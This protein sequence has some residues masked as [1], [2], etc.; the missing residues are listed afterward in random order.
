MTQAE[1]ESRRRLST[2]G[3]RATRPRLTVLAGL[4]RYKHV[5]VENLT[6]YVRLELG[7]VSIQAVYDVLAALS[8]AGLV[9]RIEPAGFPARYEDR[10]GDNHHHLICRQCDAI[11]DVD[12]VAGY[13]AC[14]TPDDDHGF[15]VDEAEI[16][17]WG[18]C[19]RCA[20]TP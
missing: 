3:L 11:V 7:S 9:R 17:F 19:P 6:E 18:T 13:A 10:V 15:A 1:I 5:S 20:S 2:A 12:C 4:R 14:L 8:Q 16:N